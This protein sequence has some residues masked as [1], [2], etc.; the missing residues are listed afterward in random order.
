MSASDTFS[1]FMTLT[2]TADRA[3][4]RPCGISERTASQFRR[5]A[6]SSRN[7]ASASWPDS[8]AGEPDFASFASQLFR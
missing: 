1:P 8:M 5:G 4:D 2:W 6:L 3:I 7:S